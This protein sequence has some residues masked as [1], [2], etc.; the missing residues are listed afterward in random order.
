MET[1]VQPQ[2]T[3]AER[4][5]K[6][7]ASSVLKAMMTSRNHRHDQSTVLQPLEMNNERPDPG[8]DAISSNGAM[9]PPKQPYARQEL[10]DQSRNREN[11]KLSPV[12]PVEVYEDMSQASGFHKKTK[13]SVSL[14]SLMGNEKT[15]TSKIKSPKKLKS[16]TGLSNLLSRPKSS[17]DLRS[18]MSRQQ[19]DKENRTPPTAVDIAAPPIWA[20]FANQPRQLLNVAKE[21]PEHNCRD[22][23]E[24]LA[25]YTPLEYSPSKQRNFNDFQNPT[26]AGR[27]ESKPRP[28]SA[29]LP[30]G[31]STTS[32]AETLSGLRKQAH[33]RSGSGSSNQNEQYRPNAEGDQKP[34]E[35]QNP[36]YGER[37]E[38]RKVSDDSSKSALT[39]ANRGSRVMAAVAAFNGKSKEPAKEIVET[40]LDVKAIE[41]AFEC[42]LVRTLSKFYLHFSHVSRT[43]EMCH[44]IHGIR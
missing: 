1:V 23:N 18:E 2:L 24:E 39:M 44:K 20:Q 16:S 27:G 22:V 38:N 42:L 37:S 33:G 31:I 4:Q 21:L 32:F 19:K 12:K 3:F 43:R 13:S 7:T 14:R 17:K 36:S 40:K 15:S 29:F 11:I 8:T 30:S 34:S 25:R 41:T 28:K 9:L 10:R 35:M 26:L 5:Q 6:K